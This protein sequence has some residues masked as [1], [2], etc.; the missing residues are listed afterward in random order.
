MMKIQEVLKRDFKSTRIEEIV[1]VDQMNE[2]TIRE[3]I[4]EYIA[5]DS[6]KQYYKELLSAIAESP[7]APHEGIGVW[8]SGFFGS[9]KS[10][11]AKNLGNALANKEI[12]GTPFSE[13]FKQQ[14]DDRAIS[15]LVDLI[16]A[17][18]PTDVIMFDVAADKAVKTGDQ[19]IAEI[20]YGVLLR[21]LDYS[22]DFDI[23]ELEIEL[24]KEG[25]LGDF[26]ELCDKKDW[27]W[28]KVR[29]GAQKTNRASLILHE[30]NAETY[31]SA[32]SWAKAKQRRTEF[33]KWCGHW[34]TADPSR[35]LPIRRVSRASGPGRY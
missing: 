24:E 16:N 28:R 15:D 31:P 29:K 6:I 34:M 11:F 32:D 35:R 7:S 18:I 13:F 10:F 21:E 8:V 12:L 3:E 14:I 25:K 22:M 2:E 9:G 17:R 26:M 23:A 20:M 5:T 1:K 27:V 4:R 30:M 19:T 33:P